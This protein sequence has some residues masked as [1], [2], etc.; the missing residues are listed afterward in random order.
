MKIRK[1]FINKIY[2]HCPTCHCGYK[3]KPSDF[4]KE[5][6]SWVCFFKKKCG[7]Q[8][9]ETLNGTIHYFK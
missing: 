3:M 4:R 5:E 2:K 1:F 9:Y 8:A 6:Y 7:L